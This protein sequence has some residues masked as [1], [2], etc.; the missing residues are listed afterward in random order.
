[1]SDLAEKALWIQKHPQEAR[2]IAMAAFRFAQTHFSRKA[3]VSFL[4]VEMRNIAQTRRSV[5]TKGEQNEVPVPVEH[6]LPP[7]AEPLKPAN[8]PASP[9]KPEKEPASLIPLDPASFVVAGLID[10]DLAGLLEERGALNARL[11]QVEERLIAIKA[12]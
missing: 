1:M 7:A 6:G 2:S 8:E 3:A 12:R 11:R 4:A 9:T 10:Q 5:S